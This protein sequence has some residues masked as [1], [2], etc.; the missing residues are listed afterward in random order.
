[1]RVG[2][3]ITFIP[4]ISDHAS[5]IISESCHLQLVYY[6]A[7]EGQSYMPHLLEKLSKSAVDAV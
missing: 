4:P 5:L 1:M 2:T 3:I 7:L 6:A